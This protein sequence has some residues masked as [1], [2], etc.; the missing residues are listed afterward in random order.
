VP[1]A[2]S[3]AVVLYRR[4]GGALEVFLVHPGGPFWQRKDDG[5]WS[6]PKGEFSA[7]ERAQDAARREFA[8]ETGFELDGDLLPLTPIRQR[9]GKIVH[10]FAIEGDCDADR[11]RSNTFELEWPPK[12][13]VRRAFPEVD[14]AGW[15]DVDSAQRKLIDGQRPVLVEL[16]ALAQ[17]RA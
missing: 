11:V 16:E 17:G 3:A 13:G 8:E 12:S 7:D 4:R 14:R 1:R 15:F 2:Q 6:F 5:A 9:S 10:P